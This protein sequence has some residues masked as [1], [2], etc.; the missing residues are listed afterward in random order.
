M[1]K[2]TTLVAA[3][4]ALAFGT[5]CGDDDGDQAQPAVTPQPV[6]AAPT[7]Q[8]TAPAAPGASNFEDVTLSTGF[9]PDP[10]TVTGTSGGA[11][12]AQNLNQACAGWVS[13]QPDHNFVA[14]TAFTNLR[15]LVNGGSGDTTLVVQKPDGSYV[16]ND[17]AEGVHPIVTGS[18]TPGTYKIWV[19]SYEQGQNTA[20]TLGFTELGSVNVASLAGGAAGGPEGESNFENVALTTGFTPDPHKVTGTSGGAVE[21]SGL[22]PSCAGYVDSTPDHLFQAQSA[23]SNLRVLAHSDQDITLVIQK[24]DGSYMCNDDAEGTDP[25]VTGSFPAGTYK[26]FIGS[27]EAGANSQY[28]LGFTELGSVTAASLAN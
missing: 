4:A 25:I 7:G 14:Q 15:I 22:N 28:T 27:Y 10:K 3:I 16:C 2:L 8:P 17:D 21:A 13:T 20:Y 12:N 18:F 11:V 9:T 5:A 26:V 23:F 6:E 1:R 19:G 24:P